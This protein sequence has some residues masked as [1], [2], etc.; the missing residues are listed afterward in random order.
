MRLHNFH[1]SSA[2]FRAR[3]ALKLKGI[4]FEYVPVRLRRGDGEQNGEDYRKLNPQAKVPLLIDGEVSIAQTVAIIEYLEEV[5]P[6]PRLLPADAVGRARVRSLSLFVACEVQPLSNLR[7]EKHLARV[8]GLDEPQLVAWRRH[9]ISV[10]FDALEVMLAA[11]ETGRF[12]HGDAPTMADCFL[13]PQVFNS[14]RPTVAL[15]LGR[16]P[17]IE[18]IYRTCLEL[19]AFAS[20]LPENQPDADQPGRH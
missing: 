19:E 7:V 6:E 8:V 2:S 17:I 10:G 18:R 14:Q 11:P 12:C 13:V 20:A 9:W 16:W 3:V 15:E 1:A 5:K 4:E